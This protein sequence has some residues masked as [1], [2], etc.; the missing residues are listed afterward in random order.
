MA[1]KNTVTLEFA[2]DEKKLTD[3]TDR[4]GKAMDTVQGRV[5]RAS[6][7]MADKSGK[8]SRFM[9]DSFK[10][11]AGSLMA[12]FSQAAIGQV[13]NFFHGMVEEARDA[14][15]VSASTAQ[16]IKTMGAES[17]IT[18]DKVGDLAEAIS[19]KIGVDD[20]LIQSSANL[21]LTFG[22]VRNAVGQNNDI[23]N[24]A[25][26]A[27]QD[28]SAKGFGDADSAAKMLGKALN[29][30]LKGLTALGKA[31]VT[32]TAAQKEQIKTMVESGDILGAQK[33]LMA[34][35]E[36]QVGGTAE[37]TTTAGDKMM[38]TWGNFQEKLGTE[39]LPIL[40]K[41]LTQLGKF[42]EWAGD[43]QEIVFAFGAVTAAVWLL[44]AAMNANPIVLITTLIGGLVAG[45]ILLWNKSDGFRNFFVGIWQDITGQVS[46][47]IDTVKS[48]WNALTDFF[49][50]TT[51][52][53]FI[54]SIFDAI[55]SAIGAVIDSIGWLIDRV[56]DAIN[57][58][59]RLIGEVANIPGFGGGGG[60][61]GG[62]TGHGTLT[63][64]HHTGG[65]VEGMLGS[66]QLRILQ[67]GERV[68]PRGQS[69]NSGGGELRI[70]GNGGLYEA[71]QYGLRTGEIQLIDSS[72]QQVQVA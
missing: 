53:R 59:K 22:N 15:K 63:K 47:A 23:F 41:V 12:N 64:R 58:A 42:V 72:G 52:G 19:N 71:I 14:A 54:V 67:A 65:V 35:V 5:G 17:W 56:K 40:D 28:L 29:D 30:P 9:S 20:E 16:G 57:W 70:T 18:A 25:V 55:G 49:T 39:I 1:N 36:K 34:E 11:A 38:V 27:A 45:L 6:T 4:V 7:D 48:V 50:K 62:F 66:E 61:G 46:G 13:T 31:G 37:A 44:N 32:F 2:G 69:G 10:V 33:L 8:A 3:S 43:N 68:V 51:L 26:L 24:R 21:L 60:L